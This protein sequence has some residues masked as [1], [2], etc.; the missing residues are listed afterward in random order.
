M[1]KAHCSQGEK[2]HYG[3]AGALAGWGSGAAEEEGSG[4]STPAGVM[5]PQRRRGLQVPGAW[6]ALTLVS[7]KEIW[8][9]HTCW[10]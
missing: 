1:R 5:W 2:T 3:A 10:P 6:L 9:V 4:C 8:I 7:R